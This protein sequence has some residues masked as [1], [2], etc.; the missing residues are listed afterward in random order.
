MFLFLANMFLCRK[1]F[2]YQ[3]FIVSYL[4]ICTKVSKCN[5]SYY[6]IIFVI[7]P[8]YLIELYNFSWNQSL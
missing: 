7:I 5:S 8:N 6:D 2:Y 3:Y 4:I 1:L